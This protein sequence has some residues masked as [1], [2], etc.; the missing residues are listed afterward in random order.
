MLHVAYSGVK[1]NVPRY[2]CQGGNINHGSPRCISFG[3][4]RVDDAISRELLS[5][6]APDGIAAA[7]RA[8]EI[9]LEGDQ[10][11]KEAL[12][13]ELEAARYQALLAERRYEASDP[14]NRLVTAE[15]EARWNAAL[16]RASE[17]QLA[18]EALTVFGTQVLPDRE[19]L[20]KLATDLP[21][22]WNAPTTPMR[23]KQ[24]IAQI[25]L[26]EIIVDLDAERHEVIALLHWRGG[27][28][29]ELRIQGNKRGE[30]AGTKVHD[31]IAVIET[32]SGRFADEA[33]ASILNRLRLKTGADN[34]WTEGR[35]KSVRQRKRLPAYDP[36]TRDHSLLT[37]DQ[38]AKRLSLSPPS[39]RRLI[40]G[41]IISATQLVPCAPWLIPAA[42]LSAA[43]VKQAA[44]A[45]RERRRLPRNDNE[46]QT[47]LDFTRVSS[48]GA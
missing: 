48:G 4:L 42:Q 35:V 12:V 13:L 38:A 17:A 10:T 45:M 18:L 23:V 15:L 5:A 26:T 44:K 9:A 46:S 2:S 19:A 27:Q 43:S 20:L 3:G 32:L 33:I 24:R 40:E 29:S 16:V 22:V 21:R 8:A 31:A 30:R 25:L 1:G 14:E 11:R 47:N 37:L 28:H 6:I 39:V 41:K 7:I 36:D 34:T